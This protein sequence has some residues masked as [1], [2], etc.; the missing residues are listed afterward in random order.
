VT[1]NGAGPLS[2]GTGPASDGAS[3]PTAALRFPLW[4]TAARDSNHNSAFHFSS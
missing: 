3:R 2:N 4:R 1:S